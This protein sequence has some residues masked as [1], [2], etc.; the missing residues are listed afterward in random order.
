MTFTDLAPIFAPLVFALLMIVLARKFANDLRPVFNNVVAGV[1]KNAQ[2]NALQY[3][4]GMAL[5][6]LSS[7]QALAEVATQFGWIYVA[8]TAKIVGPGLGTLVAFMQRPPTSAT[9]PTPTVPPFP[10]TTP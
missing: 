9:P 7:M 3:A 10:P 5:A 2:S 4:L 6:C 8:A 1:A